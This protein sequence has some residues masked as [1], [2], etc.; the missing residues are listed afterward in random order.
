M[1]TRVSITEV[2]GTFERFC[3]AAQSAGI[4]S[5]RWRLHEGSASNGIHYSVETRPYG[6]SLGLGYGGGQIGTTAREARDTLFHFA[7]AWEM[8]VEIQRATGK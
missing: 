5:S 7:R 6:G 4:D 8:L 1:S 3:K 2:R